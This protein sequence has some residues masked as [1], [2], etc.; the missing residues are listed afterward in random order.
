MCIR[1]RDELDVHAAL[2]REGQGAG[3]LAVD[4]QVGRHDVDIALGAVD[5]VQVDGLAHALVVKRIVAVGQHEAR[6]G[7]RGRNRRAQV[8][9]VFDLPLRDVPH[10]QK[11]QREAAHSGAAEHD[12]RVLPVAV[13][14]L[15]VDVFV[16]QIDAAGKGRVSVDDDDLAVIAVVVMLSLIHIFGKLF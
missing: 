14:L 16:G 15:A 13:D 8:R 7:R 4:D 1:D 6:L 2:G 10:L 11:H 3:H 5:D 12:G 9:R